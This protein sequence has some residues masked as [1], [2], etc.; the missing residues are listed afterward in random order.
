MRTPLANVQMAHALS[1][2][3]KRKRWPLIMMSSSSVLIAYSFI[4]FR[5][6]GVSREITTYP[7]L[8]GMVLLVIGATLFNNAYWDY[9]DIK[10]QEV[11]DDDDPSDGLLFPQETTPPN[12]HLESTQGNQILL[13]RYKF[14]HRQWWKLIGALRNWGRVW[15]R[16]NSLHESGIF[17]MAETGLILNASG[18]YSDLTKEFSRMKII[19][20]RGGSW[21]VTEMGWAELHKS[22]G[23]N[24][25]IT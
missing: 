6:L 15:S 19:Q 8:F 17:T 10:A 3:S 25:V 21:Y 11:S 12:V 20:K 24:G 13:S 2:A 4:A 18:V 22:A 14:S 1:D 9:L 5:Q 7:F 23:S 16:D